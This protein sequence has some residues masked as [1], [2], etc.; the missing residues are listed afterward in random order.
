MSAVRERKHLHGQR[1]IET[2]LRETP[3]VFCSIKSLKPGYEYNVKDVRTS[4]G[5]IEVKVLEGWRV[6]DEVWIEQR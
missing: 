3:F 4:D 1:E 5:G 6:P 2:A